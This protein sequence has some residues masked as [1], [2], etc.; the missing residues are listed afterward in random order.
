M[1]H[2]II[3]YNI[4][5]ITLIFHSLYKSKELRWRCPCQRILPESKTRPLL[6]SFPAADLVRRFFSLIVKKWVLMN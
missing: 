3:A 5:T 6:A 1:V 2:S 4:A